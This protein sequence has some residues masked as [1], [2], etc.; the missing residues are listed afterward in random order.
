MAARRAFML[1]ALE[2]PTT[3][4]L[5]DG[6]STVL[7]VWAGVDSVRLQ[8]NGTKLERQTDDSVRIEYRARHRDGR[9]E[10]ERRVRDAGQITEQYYRTYAGTQLLVVV[11]T[12]GTQFPLRFRRVYDP[13]P[14]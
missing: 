1:M 5:E 11:E 2:A 13:A 10:L 12:K 6:D 3:L 7:V 14:S 9:L 8:P 4:R